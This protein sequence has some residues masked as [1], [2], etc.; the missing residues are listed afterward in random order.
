MQDCWQHILGYIELQTASSID[1]SL[2]I[3]YFFSF[4]HRNLVYACFLTL[5]IHTH[6]TGFKYLLCNTESSSIISS[7]NYVRFITSVLLPRH[8]SPILDYKENSNLNRD[9]NLEP[10]GSNFSLESP[11]LVYTSSY[12]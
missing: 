9:S 6:V 10:P 1:F 3:F 8:K 7:L 11:T 12:M 2:P 5:I 4:A